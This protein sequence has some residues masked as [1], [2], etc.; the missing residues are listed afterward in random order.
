M[1]ET[2]LKLI[3]A[4]ENW[5]RH[6]ILV[7]TK[8]AWKNL[9]YNSKFR[10]NHSNELS[11]FLNKFHITL[12]EYNTSLFILWPKPLVFVLHISNREASIHNVLSNWLWTYWQCVNRDHCSIFPSFFTTNNMCDDNIKSNADL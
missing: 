1:Q 9:H 5:Y 6:A 11:V 7:S 4:T 12:F 3:L 10:N 8:M 2:F